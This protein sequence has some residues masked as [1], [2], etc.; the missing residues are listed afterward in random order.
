MKAKTSSD[1]KLLGR[2]VKKNIPS[3]PQD[4]A[5]ETKEEEQDE[6]PLAQLAKEHTLQQQAKSYEDVISKKKGLPRL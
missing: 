6:D 5:E 4:G 2:F 1:T 3:I